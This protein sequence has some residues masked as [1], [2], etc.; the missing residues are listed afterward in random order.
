[1][2]LLQ[3]NHGKKSF[4][5]RL[6]FEI[7]Q[8][9]IYSGERVG[10]IGANGTGKTTLLNIFTG[11]EEIDEGTIERYG[12]ISY[13]RQLEEIDQTESKAYSGGEKANEKLKK[14]FQNRF[15]LS[16]FDE[17]SA[18][19][20]Q[21]HQK[22]LQ[23]N[24]KQIESFLLVSHDRE[25]LNE[26]CTRIVELRE[27][28]LFSYTGNYNAYLVQRK[29]EERKKE[30]EYEAYQKEKQR[31]LTI[32]QEKK[33][34]A[35]K[36]RKTPKNMTPREAKVREF[37]NTTRSYS[38]KELRL[39]RAAEAVQKRVEHLEVKEKPKKQ[40]VIRFNYQKT[41]PPKS[42]FLI[43]CEDISFSYDNKKVLD[44]VSFD[45]ANRKKTALLGK[46]GSGKTTLLHL[47]F[48]EYEDRRNERNKKDNEKISFVSGLSIGCLEQ[49]FKNIDRTKTVWDN[50]FS[51][52]VQSRQTVFDVLAGLLFTEDALF[53]SAGILSGGELVKLSLAKLFVSE[54]N[55]LI[56]DEPT[57]YLDLPS[58]TALQKMISDYQGAI[59]FVSHDKWFIQATADAVLELENGKLTSFDGSL[60][61]WEEEKHSH[62]LRK[63]RA[64]S[65]QERIVLELQLARLNSELCQKHLSKEQ[66]IQLEKDYQDT[67][68][69][70]KEL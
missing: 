35:A 20:D 25:L 62:S 4:G 46:N 68:V 16:V 66:K 44:H 18:N 64:S 57:N 40:E 12:E 51:D 39:N 21:V 24:L 32:Y 8:F 23:R 26:V 65:H 33:S 7:E 5:D 63:N 11:Y 36:M 54:H 45:I 41:N 14:A 17:P 19:L 34:E 6:L 59:L 10:L 56:L 47:I 27:Q 49:D 13:C 9:S 30:E 38:G 50:A 70:L 2:L 42:R 52:A 58:L 29:A 37:L 1:M 53:K 60:K 69:K 48:S 31:L 43:R 28:K 55:L 3:I 22:L 61:A 67:L 15:L